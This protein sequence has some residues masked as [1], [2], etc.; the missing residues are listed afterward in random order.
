MKHN[1]LYRFWRSAAQCLLGSVGL[2]LLTFVCFRLLVN[3]T[4]ATRLYQIVIVLVS[5]SLWGLRRI[6]LFSS[7]MTC[8]LAN[9]SD[10]PSPLSSDKLSRLALPSELIE[11]HYP[12]GIRRLAEGGRLAPILRGRLATFRFQAILYKAISSC[13]HPS[14]EGGR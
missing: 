1:H 3:P 5:L 9:S 10:T 4:T 6:G 11:C 2:A 7:A 14:A 12:R 8:K 13:P